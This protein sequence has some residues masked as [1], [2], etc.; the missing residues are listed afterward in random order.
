MFEV[1]KHVLCDMLQGGQESSS[2]VTFEQLHQSGRLLAPNE[3]VGDVIDYSLSQRAP[4]SHL[5]MLLTLEG[6]KYSQKVVF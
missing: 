2:A 5:V 6:S 1:K 4:E 3:E